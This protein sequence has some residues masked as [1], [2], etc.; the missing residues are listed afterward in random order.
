MSV[1]DRMSKTSMMHYLPQLE[2]GAVEQLLAE[3]QA[4][5]PKLGVC[6]LLP[7]A[8]KGKV[9]VLQ[10]AS[11]KHRIPLVGAIFP[12]L[13]KEGHFLTSGAWLLCFKEMPH[14]ALYDNLPADAAEAELVAEKIAG[15]L[16]A[17]IDHIPD[18]TLFLLFD[19]MVPTIGTLLDNLYLHLA[20]RVHYAGANAGSETFQPMPCLFDSERLVHNGV[21]TM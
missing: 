14:F 9:E 13:V 10:A 20:N 5:Y 3:L 7:E 21:L 17:H 8:D 12:A 16:R 6:A 11:A 19:A 18:M 2:A 15:D 4:L 1:E